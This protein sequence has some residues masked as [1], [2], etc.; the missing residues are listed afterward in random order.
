MTDQILFEDRRFLVTSGSFRTGRRTL[1][2]AR[3]EQTRLQRPG[4]IIGLLIAAGSAGLV[5]VFQDLL[6]AHE[7]RALLIGPLL[8]LPIAT[9]I[10][11]LT[12]EYHG[13]GGACRIVGSATRL[14]RV[15]QAIDEALEAREG[16]R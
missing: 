2:L 8:V 5:W 16:R 12:L 15:R 11:V 6:Y 14:S 9:Q 10:G 3:V 4:L 7:I 1:R 13:L